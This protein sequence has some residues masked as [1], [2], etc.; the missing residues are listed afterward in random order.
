VDEQVSLPGPDGVPI[1]LLVAAARIK[2]HE[3]HAPLDQPPGNQ[4]L[5]AKIRRAI[6][7]FVVRRPR[8]IEAIHLNRLGRLGR[9]IEGLGRC[10]LKLKR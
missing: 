2:L 4:A 10:R 9:K 3:A 1:F 7:Q 6:R 5:P 8:L